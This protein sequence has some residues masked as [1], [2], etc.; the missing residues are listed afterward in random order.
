MSRP[1]LYLIDGSSYIFRAY[2]AIRNLTTSDGFPTN[3]VYGFSSML[4]KFVKD[5][6]PEYVA[7]VFDAK[8]KNF[9]NDI[10]A[11]YKA[12]REEAPD[13]LVPQIEKIH[14]V[15]NA[16]SFPLIIKEGY[17]ADDLIGTIAK[18]NGEKGVEVI[19]V[20]GDK[21]FCQLVSD[22]VT[23]LDTMKNKKTDTEEVIKKYGVPPEK[24]LD[25]LALCGDKVD[26]IPGVRGIG[27][28]TASKLIKEYGSLENLYNNLQ[29][30][31]KKQRS[32]LESSRDDAFMSKELVTIRTDVD[33]ET[34]YKKFKYSGFDSD[35]LR[36]IFDELEFRNLERELESGNSIKG[37]EEN[38]VKTAKGTEYKLVT[39]EKALDEVVDLIKESGELSLDLETTSHLPMNA[40]IV[41]IALT[42]KEETGFYI[43]V[44]H[45]GNPDQVQ[46]DKDLVLER[47]K[48]LLEKEEIKKIGQNLKYECIVL[49]NHGID[50]NGIYFDTMLAAHLLDSS[51]TSYRLGELSRSYLSHKMISYKDVTGKGK[52]QIGFAEVELEKAKE[53]SCEDSD[54]AMQLYRKLS[55]ELKNEGLLE[56]YHTKVLKIV[57][58]LA[59]IELNG[60]KVDL[61][62]LSELSEDFTGELEGISRDIYESVGY[63]FNLN[64]P[65][66]L[67]EV[68]FRDLNLPAKKK[69]KTG[70]PSTDYEVLV[71]LCKYHSVPELVLKYRAL[72]K[73]LST[74]IDSLPR[75]LNPGTGRLH[76]S[77]NP[78]GTTTG[79]LSSSDPNLQNI[80]IKSEEGR[81]IRRAFITEQ[82]FTL[83]S[84]DYSQI[85]L[86]LLAHYSDDEKLIDAFLNNSDIHNRTAS[87]I[88]PVTEDQVTPEMRRLSKTINFGIIYGISPYGLARQ[89]G[90]SVSQSRDYIDKYFSRYSRVQSYMERSV[91]D[92]QNKG[93]AETIIGRRRPIPELSSNNRVQRGIGE[94]AAINT[95]IQGSAADIINIAMINIHEKLKDYMSKMIL[96]VHDELIFEVAN[97]EMTDMKELVKEEME[98]ALELKVPLKVEIKTGKNW[99][100]VN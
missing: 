61:D 71:D 25:L 75:L 85:E 92:A 100:E 72:S 32:M 9:R 56:T 59:S 93:F 19:I 64:S 14:D 55:S 18:T 15:V 65:L 50:L 24:I 29:K 31:T 63:E 1:V 94:R 40:E 8:G 89:L 91:S 28:K 70:E 84:A 3:A 96:Q 47:I 83:L 74:Y 37:S 22:N 73:L 77:Y 86:R 30:L 58:V 60:V 68:L 57:K 21:D 20:T 7:M 39:K 80:P 6:N 45:V 79:R 54:I 41:G 53:Y 35:R 16:F 51:R 49:H 62:V 33:I 67:R 2:Y 69:T 44:G 11:D 42:P 23:L 97:S 99:A 26:N 13:D 46:L 36:D 4:F 78:V 76:T 12:N 90:T 81:K 38:P 66:Q 27:E 5:F 95:P 98:N 10:Y 88:F 87:E 17:E 48:P 43:P 34:D 52:S 82:G